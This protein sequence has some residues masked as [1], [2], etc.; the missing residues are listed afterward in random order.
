VEGIEMKLRRYEINIPIAV[1][2]TDKEFAFRLANVLQKHAIKFVEDTAALYP[3]LEVNP[4]SLDIPE[5]VLV[6]EW[7]YKGK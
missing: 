7:D 3:Q 5:P 1:T 2:M 4:V 6:D